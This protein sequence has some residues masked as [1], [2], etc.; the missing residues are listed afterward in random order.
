MSDWRTGLTPEQIRDAEMNRGAE[1]TNQKY[2]ALQD[3]LAR[4]FDPN[5]EPPTPTHHVSAKE[6]N[7]RL[8]EQNKER[9]K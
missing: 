9:F 8:R 5:Y 4:Q 2:G 6:Y 1:V 3:L 7:R